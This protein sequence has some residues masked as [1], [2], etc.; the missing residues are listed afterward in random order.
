MNMRI[1]H[2]IDLAK[3]GYFCPETT[4]LRAPWCGMGMDDPVQEM[5]VIEEL[6]LSRN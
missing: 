1:V 4:L 3:K 2:L 6:L 5:L